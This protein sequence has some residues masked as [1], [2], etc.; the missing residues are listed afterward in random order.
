MT[1]VAPMTA[2]RIRNVRRS[3]PAGTDVRSMSSVDGSERA[4]AEILS[5]MGSSLD[6]CAKLGRDIA[7]R[8]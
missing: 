4:S 5:V 6:E 7:R 1:V 3:T 8:Q 2:L